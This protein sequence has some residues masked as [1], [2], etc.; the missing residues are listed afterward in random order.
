MN[1]LDRQEN[2]SERSASDHDASVKQRRAEET[3]SDGLEDV[4]SYASAAELSSLL[5]SEIY[6]SSNSEEFQADFENQLQLFYDEPEPLAEFDSE[7]GEP[8]YEI[9]DNAFGDLTRELRIDQ[10]VT[11]LHEASDEQRTQIVELLGEF[12]NRK[13]RNWAGWLQ[14]KEWTGKNLLMF[15]EF[16]NH[17]HQ[18]SQWWE[19]WY[20]DKHLGWI[21]G[22]S[23]YVLTREEAYQ[24]IRQCPHGNPNE[25]IDESWFNDWESF[26]LWKH[27]FNSFVSFVRFRF[28][29]DN[30]M[31]WRRYLELDDVDEDAW[32]D[33]D[34]QSMLSPD[35]KTNV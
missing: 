3:G 5:E 33:D 7:L 12:N 4:A 10:L 34:A 35:D 9:D 23:R 29:L 2:D 28:S 13:L 8:L 22:F 17:W 18:N 11:F 26:E 6:F 15:L 25:I 21:P 19:C 1:K 24:W 32:W 31:N 20:W 16:F 30:R 14:N 27:G